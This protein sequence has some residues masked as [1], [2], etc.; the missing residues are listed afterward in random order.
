MFYI[1]DER[2]KIVTPAWSEELAPEIALRWQF[3]RFYVYKFKVDFRL[4]MFKRKST[5]RGNLVWASLIRLGF[6][7]NERTTRA[8]ERKKAESF[9]LRG[10][11][12][13]GEKQL[14]AGAA[15]AC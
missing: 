14:I 4:S 6:Q 2:K 8:R 15:A 12:A 13:C 5:L 11:N 10:K 1:T 3:L 9:E 7:W